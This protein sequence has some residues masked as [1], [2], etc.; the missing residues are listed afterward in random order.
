MLIP[1][2]FHF[3]RHVILTY[4][5]PTRFDVSESMSSTL[6]SVCGQ[7]SHHSNGITADV[8]PT[9][10]QPSSPLST[11]TSPPSNITAAGNSCIDS[12][13]TAITAPALPYRFLRIKAPKQ[14]PGCTSVS[15]KRQAGKRMLAR[16][17][18]FTQYSLSTGCAE[19][20]AI[21]RVRLNGDIIS[22]S[23]GVSAAE[24][25]QQGAAQIQIQSRN[26]SSTNSVSS[27]N[28][29]TAAS[30]KSSS[31]SSVEDLTVS[32]PAQMQ[33]SQS[34][35]ISSSAESRYS[36]DDGGDVIMS[37]SLEAQQP[38][39]LPHWTDLQQSFDNNDP[40]R[41]NGSGSGSGLRQSGRN[42]LDS[43]SGSNVQLGNQT[44]NWS[45]IGGYVHAD[46]KHGTLIHPWNPL[47][48]ACVNNSTM[49]A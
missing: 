38:Q 39:Q 23:G 34:P 1:L 33:A 4:F 32:D 15:R 41:G 36:V 5:T 22:S 46:A 16:L 12:D 45:E 44:G 29:T 24:R 19:A 10:T 25:C 9:V 40:Q 3:P 35:H 7:F 14:R 13:A 49:L 21:K 47:L 18:D 43:G 26:I 28:S 48:E 20:R 11:P 42:L 31:G 8:V 2:H 17:Y 6:P 27:R 37:Q 30:K